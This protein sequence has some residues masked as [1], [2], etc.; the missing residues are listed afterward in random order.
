MGTEVKG[1]VRRCHAAI[2]HQWDSHRAMTAIA[3]ACFLI[4]IAE[5]CITAPSGVPSLVALG[6]QL[7]CC[8]ILALRPMV[9]ALALVLVAAVGDVFPGGVDDS[10]FVVFPA[11]AVVA[12]TASPMVSLVMLMVL[13]IA[14][15]VNGLRYD[16]AADAWANAILL[17]ALYV[18]CICI[19]LAFRRK[20]E[21]RKAEAEE[22]Q[23][24]QDM[25]ELRRLRHN[26]DVARA[27]HDAVT[28]ELSAA[29]LIA[30]QYGEEPGEG[31]SPD[32][33]RR[34]MRS[35]YDRLQL[36]LDNVH[37]VIDLMERNPEEIASGNE[38]DVP[39]RSDRSVGAADGTSVIGQDV[40]AILRELLDQQDRDAAA[41]G[42]RGS[43]MVTGQCS[44]IDSVT[45]DVI[46][47]LVR[48]LYAN[49]IRHAC[50]GKDSYAVVI[51]LSADAI[52]IRQTN[53]TSGRPAPV[54]GTMHGKGLEA[55]R[56]AIER[57]GGTMRCRRDDDG[58]FFHAQIP[59]R[60]S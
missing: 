24:Q 36:A 43:S 46:R 47:D 59:V 33:A 55:H 11:L 38:T 7:G 40:S 32:E 25:A 21:V 42:F 1:L 45:L 13:E 23:R 16:T 54:S 29:S 12:Y 9:G 51:S 18:L 56:N 53:S 22:F 17:G 10:A 19:G 58:W 48:E 14:T 3:A 31:E 5:G 57:L 30:W 60:A 50:A 4:V 15:G 37:K 34:A 49:V 8:I 52:D 39:D 2:Q 35:I 28:R 26:Q 41:L 6:M 44:R 20:D 27:L